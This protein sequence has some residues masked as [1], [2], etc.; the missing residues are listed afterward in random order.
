MGQGAW[1]VLLGF[2]AN[3]ITKIIV[4][5]TSGTREF[6]VQVVPGI[7]FFTLAA[8]VSAASRLQF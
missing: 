2:T 3:N 4:A 5:A 7:L 6:A 8:W 1:A